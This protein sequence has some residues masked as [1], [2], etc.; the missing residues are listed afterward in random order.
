MKNQT[1][2]KAIGILILTGAASW[3]SA[4]GPAIGMAVADGRF[5]LDQAS[6]TG[7]GTLFDGSHI[8]TLGAPSQLRWSRG[9]QFRMGA[10]S[11]ASVYE[12]R[13]VLESGIGQLDAAPGFEVEAG[14]L[15]VSAEQSEAIARI[16]LSS[17]G[18]LTVAAFR[19]AVR[20]TNSAGLLVAKVEAGASLDFEPQAA[21][22]E[23]PTQAA[24]CLLEHAGKFIMAEQTTRIVLEVRGA[25]LD[26]EL[27]NRVRITG[28]AIKSAAGS[29]QVIEVLSVKPI[30]K[31][32][33]TAIAK[34]LGAATGA[35]APGAVA[36]ANGTG[37]AAGAA[38][39]AK[40][41]GAATAAHAA[42][43]TVA[44]IGGVAAAA[45]VG[46]LAA[47]GSLP[48]QSDTPPSAS[49]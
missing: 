32:G 21:G 27:G 39:G 37:S 4:A 12:H 1:F 8:Q 40:A 43:G 38:G 26:R 9:A 23:A 11:R 35:A 19:G 17:P 44:V 6:V 34:K 36:G 13:L 24:G 22:A 49:R 45:T 20:V 14:T 5:Y 7:N 29:A 47:V 42:K 16:G 18:H 3:L 30:A 28:R 10:A 2:V 46:G 15:H 48:G 25:G 31:G 41:A 33:C